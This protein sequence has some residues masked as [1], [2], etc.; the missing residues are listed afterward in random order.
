MKIPRF[1]TMRRHWVCWL[2]GGPLFR[3]ACLGSCGEARTA[4]ARTRTTAL[5]SPIPG[6]DLGALSRALAPR[7]HKRSAVR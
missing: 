2:C 6:N 3:G 5:V 7:L 4:P 1:S